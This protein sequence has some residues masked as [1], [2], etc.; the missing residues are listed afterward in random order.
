VFTFL[1]IMRAVRSAFPPSPTALA[2]LRRARGAIALASLAMGL[3]AAGS[4][5]DACSEKVWEDP[6]YFAGAGWIGAA[7]VL[8]AV[9]LVCIGRRAARDLAWIGFLA[10]GFLLTL[11]L[12]H[13]DQWWLVPAALAGLGV[14]YWA[15]GS[16]RITISKLEGTGVPEG[17]GAAIAAEFSA[18]TE[19]PPGEVRIATNVPDKAPEVSL[20]GVPGSALL[21]NLLAI[22]RSITPSTDLVVSGA[23]TS[24][25]EK[26][27]RLNLNL[28]RGRG[29]SRATTVS[30]RL[31]WTDQA[32]PTAVEEGTASMDLATG[33]AA[34]LLLEVL[35]MTG[36]VGTAG[37]NGA[38]R[39]QS[40]ALTFTARRRRGK[41]ADKAALA[42][43][44]RAV[45]GDPENLAAKYSLLVARSA[46]LDARTD[47][48]ADDYA[49]MARAL[50]AL[51][52]GT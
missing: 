7:L 2:R 52:S 4:L 27:Q 22:W 16:L 40:I 34:W 1:L 30:S 44:E 48:A 43:L 42:L 10:G 25:G 50:D 41:D 5:A 26:A 3:L 38:T 13:P 9:V 37:L 11:A 49:R 47:T 23:V 35:A 20:A 36:E 8:V 28:S 33:A 18:L 19:R 31:F 39:W 15:S 32:V 29:W 6:E 21:T 51:L 45:G 12:P 24:D 14:G 46:E 17:F